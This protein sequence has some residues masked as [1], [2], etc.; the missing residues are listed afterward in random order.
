MT[1][2]KKQIVEAI[3]NSFT[4]NNTDGF[5]EHCTDDIKW[6]M[7]GEK[8]VTGKDAI[9]EWIKAGE[10]E[11]PVFSVINL[12]EDGNIAICNGDMTM[13]DKDGKE[14]R[15]SYCDIYRFNSDKVAE[16]TTFVVPNDAKESTAVA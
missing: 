11:P 5:L 10:C 2:A 1:L 15:F 4:E 9:R 13:K 14:S 7:V 3:N 16:L 8:T 12:V 6:T